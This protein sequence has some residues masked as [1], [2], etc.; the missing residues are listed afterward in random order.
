MYHIFVLPRTTPQKARRSGYYI[1][2]EVLLERT[3]NTAT[4]K[5]TESIRLLSSRILEKRGL[6][7]MLYPIPLRLRVLFAE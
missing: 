1:A 4:Q 2:L 3:N 6:Q 5:K 7:R